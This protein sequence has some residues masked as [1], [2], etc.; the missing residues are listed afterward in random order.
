MEEDILYRKDLRRSMKRASAVW[1]NGL[2]KKQKDVV[3]SIHS[4]HGYDQNDMEE[5][6][7]TTDGVMSLEEDGCSLS[8]MESEVTGMP[9]TVTTFRVNPDGI[10]VD[11]EGFVTSRMQ[12]REGVKDSVMLA[13][14][15]GT[16]KLGIDTRKI[17]N[18][19]GCRGGNLE[20]DYVVNME[21]VVAM[22]NRFIIDVKEQGAI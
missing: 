10:V 17:K 4:V 2:E 13:T 21:H 15:Y 19:L 9:G 16:A 14:P 20:I 5:L 6:D 18:N 22:R 3:I 8:Y 1:R 11:R 7:F 12:F